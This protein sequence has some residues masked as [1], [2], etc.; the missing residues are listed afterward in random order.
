MADC[1]NE[2]SRSSLLRRA[3]EAG[4]GLPAIEPGMPLPAG[5]GLDRRSFVAR[6]VGLA[7]AVYGAGS[8]RVP[9]FEDGILEAASAAPPT[10]PVLV[11]VFLDGGVDTLSLLAPVGDPDY[12]RLRPK[13]AVA[14]S[15]LLV[16]G[17]DRLRWH[18]SAAAFKTL[19]DDGKLALVPAVG[20]RDADQSHFTSRH[21]W[22]VGATNPRLRTGWLGRYLDRVGSP[23]NPLQGL[24]L[25]GELAPSLATGRVPV[26]ALRGADEY[27]FSAPGVWGEVNDKMLDALGSL[28]ATRKS[29]DPALATAGE[30]ALQSDRLRRQL[31]PFKNGGLISPVA[32]PKHESDFPERLAGLA[33]MLGAGLPLRVVALNAFGMYDTHSDQPEQLGEALKVTSES[34]LAFQRDL[35]AR[36]LADRVVTLVWSEFGRR[37]EENGSDGTDHGAAGT[38]MVIGSRVRGGLVGELPALRNGLDGDGNLRATVDYRSVYCSLLE[39]WLAA[40]VIP[41]ARAYSRVGLVR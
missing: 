31:A 14:D 5:T 8:L 35:E 20:Y 37:A 22:E 24:S 3:A 19:H 39:Q 16:G 36:G 11:S 9:A 7:L 27:S 13:L 38:A 32:Y 2:F 26:A 6:S 28:G 41:N 23:A 29:G 33:S 34:L 10:S 12:R 21:Y 25:D 17:D 40:A 30:V 4:A 1:C 18:P 15:N